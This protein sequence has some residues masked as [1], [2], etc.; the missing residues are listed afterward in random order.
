MNTYGMCLYNIL[1]LHKEQGGEF[2]I[3]PGSLELKEAID[4]LDEHVKLAQ[5]KLEKERFNDF[6]LFQKAK[7]DE[8]IPLR[9]IL[10]ETA[11][12]YKDK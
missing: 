12:Y 7:L 8:G 9:E 11:K 10:E 4:I 3:L 5:D 1:K 6:I 2:L